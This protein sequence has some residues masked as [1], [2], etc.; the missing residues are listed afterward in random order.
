MD[1]IAKN[2]CLLTPAPDVIVL[3]E[4]KLHSCIGDSELGLV[5]YKI[6]RRDRFD[7]ADAAAGGGVQIALRE[8]LDENLVTID[9]QNIERIFVEIK[10]KKYHHW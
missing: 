9:S 8:S 5:G 2:V 4:T 3:T 6:F 1:I 7:V 10:G